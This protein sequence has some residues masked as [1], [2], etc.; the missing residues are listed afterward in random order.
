[1]QNIR[2][3]S[4]N[5]PEAFT[6]VLAYDCRLMNEASKHGGAITLRDWMVE[7]DEWL[8][9]QAAVL[10]PAATIEI[11]KAI[12]SASDD[13]P[14][15]VAAGRAALTILQRGL[16]DKKLQLN[17]KELQWLNRIERAFDQLPADEMTLLAEMQETYGALF[18]KKSYG[19]P[20][21]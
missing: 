14:R 10:S 4:G 3:L 6:E 19:L 20:A 9:P 16:A 2:L 8:S 18:E 7:S 21:K 1:M 11:A 15:T 17:K 13:Y 5:A 12:A